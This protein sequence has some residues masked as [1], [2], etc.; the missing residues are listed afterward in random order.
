MVAVAV[1]DLAQFHREFQMPYYLIQASYTGEAWGAQI[2]N[3][4]NRFAQLGPM[5]EKLGGSLE[6]GHYTFGDYD[7]MG[8]ARFPD[9]P[10]AAAFSLAASAG[11]AVKAIKTTPL[12]TA[13]EA[14]EAMKKASDFGYQPPGG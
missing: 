5:V 7:V 3:P 11:G 6:S 2:R 1:P 12:M 10:S 14:V 13:D 9:N 4:Q 8:I